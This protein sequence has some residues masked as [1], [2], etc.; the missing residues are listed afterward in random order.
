MISVTLPVQHRSELN[1]TTLLKAQLIKQH[2]L[3]LSNLLRRFFTCKRF[4]TVIF[5]PCSAGH[6][7][8]KQPSYTH[9]NTQ[10]N[11]NTKVKFPCLE[12]CL[13]CSICPVSSGVTVWYRSQATQFLKLCKNSHKL[14]RI[15][16]IKQRSLTFLPQPAARSHC[17]IQQP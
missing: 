14:P 4:V 12:R 3:A 5:Y 10:T 15:I 17:C 7:T 6:K 9:N 16:R 2:E 11:T 1:T 13:S 8:K